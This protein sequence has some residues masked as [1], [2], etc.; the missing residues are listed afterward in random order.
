LSVFPPLCILSAA[1]RKSTFNFNK[2]CFVNQ[3]LIEAMM[4]IYP[5]GALHIVFID[6]DYFEAK[7]P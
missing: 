4:E 7:Q 5:D 2:N 6:S 1:K 3:D